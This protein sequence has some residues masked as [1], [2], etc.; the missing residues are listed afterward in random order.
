MENRLSWLIFGAGAIGTYIG[1]SLILSGQ[2]VVFIERTAAATE[3]LEYG[4]KLNIHGQESRILHPDITTSLHESLTGAHFDV[5]VLAVKSYDTQ[6]VLE[7]MIPF[8]S[9]LPPI[10]CVQN[11]VDNEPQLEAVLGKDMV[12]AGTVTSSILRRGAGDV[13]VERQ[14]GI[15]IAQDHPIS[16]KIAQVLSA[17]GIDAQLISPAPA[18]KWSKMLTNLMANASSAILDMTP[19]EILNHPKLYAVEISQLREALSVMHSL[20]I[21]IVDL[22]K[23]P[24]RAF[25]WLVKN[26]PLRI[27]RPLLYKLAGYG[28]GQKMP[29]FHIDLYSGQAKSE[30][31]YLN[32]AINRYGSKANVSTPVNTWLSDT[33]LELVRGTVPRGYY[34]RQP[35]KYL[36]ALYSYIGKYQGS[37]N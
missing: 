37:I 19:A 29:S 36:Q 24:V 25:A 35:E 2:K 33:L 30:V 32:G 31:D 21:Q 27:S 6:V 9:Q 5:A 8:A 17:S 14:R 7:T 11:G 23:V 28:R 22:P 12:I 10:L 1:G 18:M 15:G 26:I 34:S 4:L 3:I 20:N 13:L 16:P